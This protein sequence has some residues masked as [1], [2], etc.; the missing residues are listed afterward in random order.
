MTEAQ[1]IETCERCGTIIEEDTTEWYE[2]HDEAFDHEHQVYED[3]L[4]AK[5]MHLTLSDDAQP[6]LEEWENHLSTATVVDTC[7]TCGTIVED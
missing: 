3:W 1:I 7:P 5:P 4:D 2:A 6:S